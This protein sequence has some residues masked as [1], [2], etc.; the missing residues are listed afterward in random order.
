MLEPSGGGNGRGVNNWLQ[1][2]SHIIRPVHV[3]AYCT[4]DWVNDEK[5]HATET[6]FNLASLLWSEWKDLE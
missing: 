4:H 5:R 3:S 6:C 1:A 2:P